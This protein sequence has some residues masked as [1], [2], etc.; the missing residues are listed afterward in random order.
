MHAD[1]FPLLPGG[2]FVLI[3]SLFGRGIYPTSAKNALKRLNG[4]WNAGFC[5]LGRHA[6]L[7][8]LGHM[9]AVPAVL[10][11]FALVSMIF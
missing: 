11:F 8:Y 4:P 10:V 7:F 9:A 3:G 6:A 5:F 1:D 2:A